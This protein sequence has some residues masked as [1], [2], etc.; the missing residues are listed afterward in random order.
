LTGTGSTNITTAELGTIYRADDQ[1]N[2]IQRRLLILI[3]DAEPDSH[4]AALAGAVRDL[5]DIVSAHTVL[6]I[7]VVKTVPACPVAPQGSRGN[8]PSN[9]GDAS[10]IVRSQARLTSRTPGVAS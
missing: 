8:P 2:Q 7:P 4:F 9:P 3:S 1:L 10:Q 6:P 5:A